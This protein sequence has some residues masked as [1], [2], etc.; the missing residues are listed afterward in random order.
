MRHLSLFPRGEHQLWE[1]FQCTLFTILKCLQ[2]NSL[3][4]IFSICN[5]DLDGFGCVV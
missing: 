1:I 2:K 4:N 5:E 3:Q